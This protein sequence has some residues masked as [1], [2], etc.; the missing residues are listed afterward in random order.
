[1]F[2]LAGG[3]LE[4]LKKGTVGYGG[5]WEGS[6]FLGKD[7]RLGGEEISKKKGRGQE[8]WFLLVGGRLSSGKVKN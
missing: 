4:K 1:V 2:T 6:F 7:D 8:I 5:E 3:P